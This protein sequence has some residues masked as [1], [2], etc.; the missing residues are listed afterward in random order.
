MKDKMVDEWR[1]TTLS[2]IHSYMIP[3]IME[4]MH[5]VVCWFGLCAL[6]CAFVLFSSLPFH[7]CVCVPPLSFN[8]S[9]PSFCFSPPPPPPLFFP[10]LPSLSKTSRRLEIKSLESYSNKIYIYILNVFMPTV[11]SLNKNQTTKQIYLEPIGS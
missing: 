10:F 5:E 2:Y 11:S 6:L 4:P 9:P 3:M 8:I 7:Q 1:W